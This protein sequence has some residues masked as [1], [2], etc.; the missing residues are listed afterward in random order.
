MVAALMQAE[1]PTPRCRCCKECKDCFNGC[2]NCYQRR[3]RHGRIFRLL[4]LEEDEGMVPRFKGPMEHNN[5]DD[6]WSA[7]EHYL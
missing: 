2:S 7:W 1:Y 6:S 3:S 4:V 5:R